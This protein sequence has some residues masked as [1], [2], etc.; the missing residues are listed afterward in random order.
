MCLLLWSSST[1]IWKTQ[2]HR[3][4]KTSLITSHSHSH[5]LPIHMMLYEDSELFHFALDDCSTCWSSHH[6]RSWVKNLFSLYVT[7]LHC[8]IVTAQWLQDSALAASARQS[9]ERTLKHSQGS[10]LQLIILT[11]KLSMFI[12]FHHRSASFNCRSSLSGVAGM[13]KDMLSHHGQGLP[14]VLVASPVSRFYI[15]FWL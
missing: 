15:V 14:K 6:S 5:P 12:V 10:P 7:L 1:L 3:L 8:Y 13:A 9:L 4:V 11:D 2:F